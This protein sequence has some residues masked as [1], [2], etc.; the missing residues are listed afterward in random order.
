MADK[1][2]ESGLPIGRS[3]RCELHDAD[4]NAPDCWSETDQEE[5]DADA[6][7]DTLDD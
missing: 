4:E 6:F 5:C 7:F 3:G 2:F 1:C